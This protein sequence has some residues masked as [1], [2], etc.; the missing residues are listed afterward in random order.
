[1]KPAELLLSILLITHIGRTQI[2]LP[3]GYTSVEMDVNGIL[4]ENH[5]EFDNVTDAINGHKKALYM[6]GIDTSKTIVNQI[7]YPNTPLFSFFYKKNDW[8]IKNGYQIMGN[9]NQIGFGVFDDRKITPLLTLQHDN[10]VYVYNTDFS[11]LDKASLTNEHNISLSKIKDI[12]RTDH[13]D[14]FYTLNIE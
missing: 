12:Y 10:K 3:S 6:N 9:L 8:S 2:D 14:S 7:K 13:L 11:L 1:M 5:K 4:R